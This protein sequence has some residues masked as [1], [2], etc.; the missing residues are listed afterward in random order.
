MTRCRPGWA[1]V[2]VTCIR[3]S[4]SKRSGLYSRVRCLKQGGNHLVTSST[5]RAY[6]SLIKYMDKFR[7]GKWADNSYFVGASAFN[8]YQWLWLN[9]TRVV[10]DILSAIKSE[11][12]NK[13]CAFLRRKMGKWEVHAASCKTTQLYS[14]C[15][16]KESKSKVCK[17]YSVMCSSLLWQMV[18]TLWN[19]N[20][21]RV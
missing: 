7:Y 13:N 14:L 12:I 1:A 2:G 18:S 6:V 5:T 20:H 15:S 21:L 17:V 9:R 16:K 10:G 3:F 8:N 19:N 4:T 11:N